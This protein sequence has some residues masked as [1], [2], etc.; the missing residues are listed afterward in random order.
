M[1]SAPLLLPVARDGPLA[2]LPP[3]VISVG[4]E[5]VLGGLRRHNIVILVT[6]HEPDGN[7]FIVLV[8]SPLH[9]TDQTHLVEI[10]DG[11]EL[12]IALVASQLKESPHGKF[13]LVV[14]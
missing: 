2:G 5:E 9:D 6:I 7:A 8:S 1:K 3:Q 14:P 13:P 10:H 11:Q 12:T 4:V